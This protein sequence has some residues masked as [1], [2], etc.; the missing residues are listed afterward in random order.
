MPERLIAEII[1]NCLVN[2]VMLKAHMSVNYFESDFKLTW[3]LDP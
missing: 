2:V 3:Q 1:E